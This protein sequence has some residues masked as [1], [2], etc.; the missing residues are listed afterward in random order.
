MVDKITFMETLRSVQ[1][2][3]KTGAGPMS[4]EEVQSYFQDMELSE[5]QQD[6]IYQYLQMPQETD[7]EE[8]AEN[9]DKPKT[10]GQ[11]VRKKG[12]KSEEKKETSYSA[13]FRMY[14]NEISAVPAL[15]KDQERNLYQR[16]LA[17]DE[18]VIA[19]LSGQWLKKVIR[20][21]EKYTT[22]KALLEDLV[23]EGNMG[24]LL[25]LRQLLGK[26]SEYGMADD[27][28]GVLQENRKKELEQKLE[29]FVIEGLKSYRRELEGETD[30]ENTILAKVSLVYEA[31][32][33]L[34]EENGTIPTLQ[35]LCEY[36]RIPE[37][38]ISDILAL[39]EKAE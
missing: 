36:T 5:E 23:Q 34:A 32:K 7:R 35:E 11:Q 15:D 26:G 39:H 3:A 29:E 17:G 16:L 14:L 21:A 24:L 37:K 20:L 1:E 8:P 22:A 6:M 33:V 18:A 2:I 10:Q 13:H 12:S 31:R 30:N 4:R 9:E 19:D 38:E 25:G 28:R 27:G